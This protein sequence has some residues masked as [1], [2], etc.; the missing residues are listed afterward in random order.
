M[1]WFDPGQV[2]KSAVAWSWLYN[3]LRLASGLLLLPLLY[4]FLPANDFGMHYV[5]FT[6]SYLVWI[7]DGAFSVTIGRMASY[8][9]S[10][11]KTL[12]GL[13]MAEVAAGGEPNY[14]LL[15]QLLKTTRQI[16]FLMSLAVL[17]LLGTLGTQQVSLSVMETSDPVKTWSA[18][19]L[20]LLA[21]PLDLH[22]ASYNVFLRGMNR[23][24]IAA[25]I[26]TVVYG[27]RLVLSCV[28]LLAGEGL[29][30]VPIATLITSV[31]QFVLNRYY[32]REALPLQKISD[33]QEKS[34]LKVVWPTS[35]RVGLQL[36][37]TYFL[38][39]SLISIVSRYFGLEAAGQYGL[40]VQILIGIAQGVSAVWT[41][42]K[43][44]LVGQY[45]AR[46]D[47]ASMRRVLWP[48]FWLQTG[49]MVFSLGFAIVLGPVLLEWINPNK[50][51]LP[52]E[53]LFLLGCFSLLDLNFSFWT[54]LLSLENRIPSLWPTVITN[55][56]SFVLALLFVEFSQW[57][58]LSIILAP[59]IS[60]SL[61]NYWYFTW[62]G[63]RSLGTTWFEFLLGRKR[64]PQ[65]S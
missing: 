20:L 47:L 51:M 30:S 36:F 45:R 49:T 24:L 7:V 8:A 61:F 65:F 42:V 63:A 23:V 41:A 53:W 31:L 64:E 58:L 52:G 54:V 50:K 3:G 11:A 17:I 60:G 19:W 46:N 39:V 59:L 29:K 40:S 33:G 35:W 1:K 44:P 48:R 55:L 6:Y 16:Y 57:G 4:R 43:W 14:P 32:C 18:W 2:M 13:G 62:R 37:S 10:G 28:L 12:Q 26:S 21:T 22:S 56:C 27:M 15:Y 9:M 5:F 34:L 25:K 38:N